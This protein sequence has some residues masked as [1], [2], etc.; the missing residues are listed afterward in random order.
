MLSYTLVQ[1]RIEHVFTA[2]QRSIEVSSHQI[3]RPTG[4]TSNDLEGVL[5]LINSILRPGSAQNLAT[6]YPL[7]YR[8]DNLDRIRIIKVT[9]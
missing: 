9:G 2:L 5:E 1:F 4:C 8:E 7:V 6:D 3:Q